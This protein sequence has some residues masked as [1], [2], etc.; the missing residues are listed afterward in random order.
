MRINIAASHRF[1]LLD[2][3]RELAALGHDVRFYSYVPRRRCVAYGLPKSCAHSFTWLALPFLALGKLLGDPYWLLFIRNWLIDH[4][5]ARFMRPCDVFIGQG[6]V[7]LEAYKAAKNRFHAFTIDDWGS[8]HIIENL[9]AFGELDMY[10]SCFLKRDLE[11]YAISDVI[12]IPAKHVKE[13]FVKQGIPDS[14]LFV[15]PY[16]VS[17]S[18]F[19]PTELQG[20]YD[21]I[22]VGGW[23]KRKG[24]H[25]L[26][27]LCQRYHYKL[28]HVGAL[29]DLPFPKE[30][31][32]THVDAVDQRR[33]VDY[34]AKA[35]VFVLPSLSEG[36]AMVQAQAIVCGL[37]VVCSANSGGSDLGIFISHPENIIVMADYSIETLHHCVEEALT[38]A[39]KQSGVRDY[40]GDVA[41]KLSWVAYGKRYSHF[42]GQKLKS[43][44]TRVQ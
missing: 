43:S 13:G 44:I 31:N 27:E 20:D 34:Y 30:G 17:L 2:L 24:C 14:K 6:G 5:V 21:L 19:H 38:I 7:Y 40:A 9:K 39:Q 25:L 28:L 16:G 8:K 15:N 35:K 33:L 12:A 41:S 3:A 18:Q 4:Y 42:L 37:P 29:V 1:H 36:L 23:R 32:F 26:V 10:P 11:G 22:L